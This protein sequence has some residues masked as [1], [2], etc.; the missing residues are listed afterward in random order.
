VASESEE[1]L[2]RIED[3]L[4]GVESEGGDAFPP[5]ASVKRQLLWCR[6][7]LLGERDGPPPG[8]FTMG[9]IATRE[10]DMYGD[11]P[12]LA[13]EINLIEGEVGRLLSGAG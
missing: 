12:G 8:P 3:A 2:A 10:L 11:N 7:F 1:L 13:L 5:M 9:L 4:A 6:D